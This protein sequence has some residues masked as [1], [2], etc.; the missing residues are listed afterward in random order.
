MTKK[1]IPL[2]LI[3]YAGLLL[4]LFSPPLALAFKKELIF[5]GGPSGGTF[6]QVVDAIEAYP[7]AK[8]L[9]NIII[10]AQPSA[11]SV[12]NLREVH[13]GQADFGLV[14]SSHAYLA[15]NG[16]LQNDKQTYSKVLAVASL[17]GAPAQLVVRKGTGIQKAKDLKGKRVGVGS[18]GSGAFAN[19]ELFF[20]HLGVWDAII[21][22]HVNYNEVALAFANKELD[23][24]WLFSAFPSNAIIKAAGTAKVDLLDLDAEAKASG[25][26]KK[27]P[28]F[29]PRT[30]PAGTY[31]GV[32]HKTR[33][34]QNSTL[35][36]SNAEVP[37]EMVYIL[38][39]TLY[40]K[41]GLHYLGQQNSVLKDMALHSG[42]K[43]V[44]IPMHP[45]A[46]KFWKK[47]GI[48]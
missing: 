17:Y 39:S 18:P 23:A 48:R 32:K 15:R 9:S 30:L 24:F 40:D 27:Y 12:E 3:I 25:F 28:Y 37:E 46:I 33:T 42:A 16:L 26:Y 22:V 20:R 47:K 29:T 21:P 10:K 1:P 45:G 43:G 36:V 19:C 34:F 8:T 35:L 11:G 14:Y 13:A 44:S 2:A 38:L 31:R 4:V 5:Q 41:K 6:Q 7:G